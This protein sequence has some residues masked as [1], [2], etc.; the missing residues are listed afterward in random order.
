MTAP[1]AALP[2]SLNDP[3]DLAAYYPEWD[4]PASGY[5]AECRL[6]SRLAAD[7]A[8]T[9]RARRRRMLRLRLQRVW[10]ALPNLFR[11]SRPA[12]GRDRSRRAVL[13]STRS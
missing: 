7:I 1:Y 3:K 10:R 4:R 5:Q 11:S 2:V 13:G 9:R 6:Y 8:R 12:A